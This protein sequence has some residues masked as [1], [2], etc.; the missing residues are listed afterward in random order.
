MKHN[1]H[2]LC[3]MLSKHLC[4]VM[5]YGPLNFLKPAPPR[6]TLF[7]EPLVATSVNEKVQSHYPRMRGPGS[8]RG[9]GRSHTC[10]QIHNPDLCSVAPFRG[11]REQTPPPFFQR[12]DCMQQGAFLPH[13]AHTI[14]FTPQKKDCAGT[15][16][17]AKPSGQKLVARAWFME[18]PS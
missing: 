11:S 7:N 16:P 6:A 5:F 10:P 14:F 1:R 2:P 12:V 17:L 15:L 18:L 9:R 3:I 8:L 13:V 4:P